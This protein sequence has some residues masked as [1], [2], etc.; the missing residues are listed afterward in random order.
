MARRIL[1][2]IETG[3]P[4]GAERVVLELLQGLRARGHSVAL[5]TLRQGWLT[6]NALAM[7]I[8]YLP[9]KSEG[10]LD[11]MLPLR[12]SRLMRNFGADVLH[13]HLLDSNFYG[14]LS[15]RL[16]PVKHI[17]T[18]HGDVHHLVSKKFLKLKLKVASSGGSL[19]TSVSQFTAERLRKL[20]V[21]QARIKVVPNPMPLPAEATNRASIREELSVGS[22]WLWIHVGNLRPV[23]DQSTLIRGFAES[24]TSNPGQRMILIGDGS[25]RDS[26]EK[27]AAELNCKDMVR[28]LG[29]RE[30]V[31]QLLGAAD[32]FILSSLSESMPMA[33]LEAISAGLC[34][35][36]TPVGGVPE[37]LP[38]EN[39]FRDK[40]QLATLMN[41]I[42]ATQESSR[43]SAL[44]LRESLYT[45]RSIDAVLDAYEQLY[46]NSSP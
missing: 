22:N 45:S 40:M 33:L 23:K 11:L 24:L 17:G 15:A 43:Q 37:I 34:C 35:L 20:G 13:T 26:L 6:E 9:L 14:A 3:G 10:R 32:G 46:E 21:S 19:I 18:E 12:L 30:D 7:G 38:G 8:E 27:L 36:S 4:G 25:E 29:H 16:Y 2:F 31:Q 1:F 42:L 5:S 41:Q 28:F 39:L 44:T